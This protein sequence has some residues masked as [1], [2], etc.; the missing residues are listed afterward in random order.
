MNIENSKSRAEYVRITWRS[1]VMSLPG[2]VLWL[3]VK[4]KLL[5]YREQSIGP[6]NLKYPEDS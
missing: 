2:G 4:C 5:K 6:H 1:F 3:R